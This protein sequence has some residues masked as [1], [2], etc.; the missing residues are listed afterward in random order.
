[1]SPGA[2]VTIAAP[3][4]NYGLLGTWQL[5]HEFSFIWLNN[6]KKKLTEENEKINLKY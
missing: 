5:F 1:L 3:K 6:L 4:R 2:L